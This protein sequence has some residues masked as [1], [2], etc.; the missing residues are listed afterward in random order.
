MKE[1]VGTKFNRL[2]VVEDYRCEY[3]GRRRRMVKCLCECGKEVVTTKTSIINGHTKSCGCIKLKF[4]EIEKAKAIRSS[5]SSMRNRCHADDGKWFKYYKA[6][7]IMYCERWESFR[8]FYEDMHETWQPGLELDRIKNEL[9]YSKENCRWNTKAGQQRNKTNNK[10][11]DAIVIEIR[12][13]T[14]STKELASKYNVH[15]TTI[16]RIKQGKRWS[17]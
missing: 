1:V 13:S 3:G 9:G 12:H 7:G 10:I 17:L 2:V 4:T 16:T 14:Q 8:Y 15:G 5:Y 6:K 11:T